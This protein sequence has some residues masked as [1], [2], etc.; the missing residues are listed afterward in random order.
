MSRIG[1]HAVIEYRLPLPSKAVE[2]IVCSEPD[3]DRGFE[4]LLQDPLIRLVMDSDGVTDEAM[5]ALL[6]QLRR[7]ATVRDDR[8]GSANADRWG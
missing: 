7:S 8:I 5:I 1:Q 3:D 6:D 2:A 4:G